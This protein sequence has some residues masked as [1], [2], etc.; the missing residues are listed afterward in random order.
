MNNKLRVC[1]RGSAKLHVGNGV[2]VRYQK[3]ERER[4]ELAIVVTD[5]TNLEEVERV[6]PDIKERLAVLR[7]AQG[8][9]IYSRLDVLIQLLRLQRKVELHQSYSEIADDMNEEFFGHLYGVVGYWRE[10]KLA[11]AR[12]YF[13]AAWVMLTASRMKDEKI[14]EVISSTLQTILEQGELLEDSGPIDAQRV[15]DMLRQLERELDTG[16]IVIPPPQA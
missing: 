3:Q 12:T 16:K 14:S 7:Q 6:W 4:W 11:R 2:Y 15:R 13:Q 9:D 8:S 1:L 10:G 5:E